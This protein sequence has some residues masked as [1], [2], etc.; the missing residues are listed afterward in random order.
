MLS[1]TGVLVCRERVVEST[2]DQGTPYTLTPKF[3]LHW[4]PRKG[5]RGGSKLDINARGTVIV[6]PADW[7]MQLS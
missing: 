3:C 2:V 1:A 4:S 5:R 6:Y 7:K